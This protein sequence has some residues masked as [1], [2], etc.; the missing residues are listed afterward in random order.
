M[1][2]EIRERE[3]FVHFG[4]NRVNLPLQKV[5]NKVRVYID[6]NYNKN[7]Y[8]VSIS[9]KGIT[10]QITTRIYDVEFATSGVENIEVTLTNTQT[11]ETLTSNSIVAQEIYYSFDNEDIRFDNTIITF[12]ND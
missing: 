8:S 5:G 10:T 11:G 12:D 6:G 9:T 2:K 1:I 4:F 3:P 7:I